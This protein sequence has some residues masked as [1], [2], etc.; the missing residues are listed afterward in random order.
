MPTQILLTEKGLVVIHM[1][2]GQADLCRVTVPRWAKEWGNPAVTRISLLQCT[3]L[4]QP[5]WIY[6]LNLL[7]WSGSLV[8]PS[9]NPF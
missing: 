7:S 9:G 8:T 5:G 2:G 6:V 3:S 4:W 1:T